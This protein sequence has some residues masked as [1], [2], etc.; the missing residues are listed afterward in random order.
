MMRTFAGF[1]L[2]TALAIASPAMAAQ[3]SQ[4]LGSRVLRQGMNGN[5]V[6]ALQNMLTQDGFQTT[7]SGHFGAMTERNVLAFERAFGLKANGIVTRVVVAQL[8]SVASGSGGSSA[9]TTVKAA[10]TPPVNAP[11]LTQG[12]S[13]RWVRVLQEDLTFAGFPTQVDGQFGPGTAQNV[14][15]F[16]QSKGLQ[17]NSVVGPKVWST[18]QAAVQAV[19]SSPPVGKARLNPN[20][21][22]TAPSDAPPAVQTMIA[23]ANKIATLPYCYGGGHG[24]WIDT[25]YDCSGSTG[26]VL[27]AAGLLSVTEASGEMESYGLPGAGRWVT[28]FANAGHVYMEIAGLWFDTAAQGSNRLNDRWSTARIS[29]LSGFVVRHPGG[30]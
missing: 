11:T 17:A 9:A 16:K 24:R 22:V 21:L 5:D 7:V 2:L 10:S 18:L 29:P 14:I 25:C 26:Y 15:A 30:L 12:A 1:A 8:H 23:A 3:S 13:G 28:M 19:Q 4:K 27:H 20:G 6:R